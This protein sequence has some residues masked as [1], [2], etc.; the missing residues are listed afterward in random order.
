MPEEGGRHAGFN[1]LWDCLG[2]LG[3][4]AVGGAQQRFALLSLL[5]LAEVPGGL[6]I[7]GL[8][9]AVGL[10]TRR[11]RRQSARP[12]V[13]GEMLWQQAKWPPFRHPP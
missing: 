13:N 8:G 4:L 12:L 3:G 10:V 9:G 7:A 5:L 11:Q 2:L 6:A 1:N